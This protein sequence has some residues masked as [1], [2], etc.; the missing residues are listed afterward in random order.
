MQYK[1]NYFSHIY[2]KIRS[3]WFGLCMKIITLLTFEMIEMIEMMCDPYGVVVILWWDS[4]FY[5]YATPSG[6]YSGRLVIL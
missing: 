5:K 3:F 2:L 4:Y 6:S 1:Y